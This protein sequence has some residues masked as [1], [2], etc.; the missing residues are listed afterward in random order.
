MKSEGIVELIKLQGWIPRGVYSTSSG[1]LL[2]TMNSEDN[3]QT[4]GVRY[5]GY[6]EKQNI[7]WDDE[8]RPLYTSSRLFNTK[9]VNENKY[10]DIHCL[11]R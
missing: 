3:E 4:K 7:Q 1:D 10:V 8:G 6:T 2:V 5:S 11:C 9:N